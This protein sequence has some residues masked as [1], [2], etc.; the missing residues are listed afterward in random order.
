M[1]TESETL[2]TLWDRVLTAACLMKDTMG[3]PYMLTTNDENRE[4]D[5][6]DDLYA[7]LQEL[8]SVE[9]DTSDLR[10]AVTEYVLMREGPR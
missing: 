1:T 9:F 6:V 2:T 4:A 7:W 8:E 3:V 5:S 10:E